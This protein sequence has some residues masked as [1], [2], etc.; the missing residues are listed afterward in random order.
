MFGVA[1][2][3]KAEVD[4]GDTICGWIFV[5][6]SNFCQG[7]SGADFGDSACIVSIIRLVTMVPSFHSINFTVFKVQVGESPPPCSPS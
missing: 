5:S 6:L 7:E 4:A 3:E 2:S 1:G